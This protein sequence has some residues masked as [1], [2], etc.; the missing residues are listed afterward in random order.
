MTTNDLDDALFSIP[1]AYRKPQTSEVTL[2]NTQS[3]HLLSNLFQSYQNLR[4]AKGISWCES[5][6]SLH[7]DYLSEVNR[8]ANGRVPILSSQGCLG[9]GPSNSNPG[10][11]VYI[12][13]GAGIPFILRQ[14]ANGN[15]TLLGEAYIYRIMYGEFLEQKP[16]NEIERVTLE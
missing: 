5:G 12:F 3:A 2:E 6:A 8:R 7:D 1:I 15:F 4:K 9:I 10:D 13:P 16:N 14:L 11:H